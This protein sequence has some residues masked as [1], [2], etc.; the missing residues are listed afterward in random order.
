MDTGRQ[1][2]RDCDVLLWPESWQEGRYRVEKE[3]TKMKAVAE[4]KRRVSKMGGGVGWRGRKWKW[5]VHD[6]RGS[7]QRSSR[8]YCLVLVC[9][10]GKAA[11]VQVG[12]RISK[13]I[14]S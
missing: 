9:T 1:S 7:I 10:K 2:A 14:W 8:G 13:E 12:I 11:T 6:R 3:R 5:W 4:R